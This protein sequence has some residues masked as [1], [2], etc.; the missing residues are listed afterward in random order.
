MAV[1]ARVQK[2]LIK[3]RVDIEGRVY[4]GWAREKRPMPENFCLED[5]YEESA[6]CIGLIRDR[7]AASS[8]AESK[9]KRRTRTTLPI[10]PGYNDF[11]VMKHCSP[12]AAL[13]LASE[14]DRARALNGWSIP[15][16]DVHRWEPEV[17]ALLDEIG[18]FELLE[19]PRPDHKVP[20]KDIQILQFQ[21]GRLVAR[22]EV[23]SITGRLSSL[24]ISD[25]PK[26][27]NDEDF[28]GT[29][30]QLLGAIQ[31]ATENSCHHAYRNTTVPDQNKRWWATGA[32][33]TKTR[34]LNLSVY[35]QGRSIPDTLPEWDKYPFVQSRLARFRR[36]IG[37][38]LGEDEL[39][40][41][42]IR[43]AMD[44]PRSS[45]LQSY[46]GKGF[47][48]FK[49]VVEQSRDAKLRILSRRGEF[50]YEKGR[51]PRAYSLNTPLNGTLVE[52]D[53][54]V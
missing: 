52:W 1:A 50:I 40:A 4:R 23:A 39:D 34:H 26:L 18:F 48:L 19:I 41:V 3:V 9:R 13:V 36:F 37:E 24:L 20:Q 16:I 8:A 32:I 54:W 25:T 21:T 33:N 47:P 29:I 5:N 46:R 22:E 35:D 30:M 44:A 28:L 14:F 27:G 15:L 51:H 49:R 12:S 2:S 42:K 11:T 38:I 10:I 45:T 53:L 31:E 43:L 7:L 17:V 6:K